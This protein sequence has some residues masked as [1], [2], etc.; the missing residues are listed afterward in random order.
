MLKGKCLLKYTNLSS[1]NEYK[2]NDKTILKSF[3][4]EPKWVKWW[5]SI[6]KFAINIANL[7]TLKYHIF[8][9]KIRLFYCLQ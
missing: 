1:P 7:Q 5:K 6:V 3:L 9:K 2:M 8:L 4:I